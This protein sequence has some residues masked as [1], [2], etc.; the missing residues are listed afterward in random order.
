VNASPLSSVRQLRPAATVVVLRDTKFG[1]EVFMVRR[2]GA[3]A[4]M[5]GAHVFPGGRVDV[6][7]AAVADAAWCAGLEAAGI[8]PL[9]ASDAL[10]HRIA[11]I[12]EL[13]EE[14]AVLLALDAQGHLAATADPLVHERFAEYRRQIHA[15][16]ASLR[17]IAVRE[18]LRL[19]LDALVPFARWITPPI[20]VRQFDAWFFMTRMPP[21]QTPIHDETETTHGEWV[22]PADALTRAAIREIILPPPTWTTLREIERFATVDDALAWARTRRIEP[23]QPRLHETV[24]DRYLLL[25]GDPL[26]PEGW[27]E[28]PPVETRFRFDSGRWTAERAG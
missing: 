28:P 20:D 23:R 19:S 8:A 7:D 10:A 6:G 13:F 2:H 24:T 15:A 22:R 3:T 12:R 25:P 17:E 9:P 16:S 14:A 5:G 21:E 26:N 4:F 18:R 27:H 1:L 11:A